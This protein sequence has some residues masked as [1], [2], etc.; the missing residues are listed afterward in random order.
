MAESSNADRGGDQVELF[1]IDQRYRTART[2]L[3]AAAW[4]FAAYC[5]WGILDSLAGRTTDVS[6]SLKGAIS[7]LADLKFA[8]T[9][10]LAGAAAAWAAIERWLRHRTI[11]NLQSRIRELETAVDPGRTS[12]GLTEKGTTHPRDKGL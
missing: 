1:R 7:L 2:G 9:I 12:S 6:V 3:K 11:R 8:V 10:T 4:V 5:L